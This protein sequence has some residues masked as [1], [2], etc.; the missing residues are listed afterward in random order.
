[1]MD[2]TRFLDTEME[3]PQSRNRALVY[4][5]S[6]LVQAIEDDCFMHVLKP[7]CLSLEMRQHAT[8]APD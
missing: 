5:Q 6:K 8:I 7:R 1:M 3:F 4:L 2:I